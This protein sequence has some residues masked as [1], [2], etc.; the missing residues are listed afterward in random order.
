M[1]HHG[2]GC[3]SVVGCVRSE[4]LYGDGGGLGQGNVEVILQPVTKDLRLCVFADSF[5]TVEADQRKH[6]TLVH[7]AT[8]ILLLE[9]VKQLPNLF[10]TFPGGSE[11]L[12][13]ENPL[14]RRRVPVGGVGGA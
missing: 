13:P 10:D 11:I 7:P 1:P 8:V 12:E 9:L 4:E 2:E 5:G 3:F 14:H 6:L